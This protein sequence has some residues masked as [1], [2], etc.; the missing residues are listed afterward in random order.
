MFLVSSVF[1]A[2]AD[3]HAS[4]FNA[5]AGVK[6]LTREITYRGVSCGLD[7]SLY[8]AEL[9]AGREAAEYLANVMEYAWK[10]A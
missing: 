7:A 9:K 2:Y 4:K 8:V 6:L 3:I 1:E 5:E 10:R